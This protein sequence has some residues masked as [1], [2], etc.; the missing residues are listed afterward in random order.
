MGTSREYVHTLVAICYRILLR[1]R[2]V[3][4]IVAEITEARIQTYT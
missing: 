4:D 1:V 3:S 2:S